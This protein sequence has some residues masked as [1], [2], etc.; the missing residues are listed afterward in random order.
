MRY[1]SNFWSNAAPKEK[2]N[3]L[4]WNLT[5]YWIF[6]TSSIHKEEDHP[7]AAFGLL[8]HSPG[9]PALDN[10]MKRASKYS[11]VWAGLQNG[12]QSNHSMGD[13]SQNKQ[14]EETQDALW[15]TRGNAQ[16][17]ATVKQSLMSTRSMCD[18]PRFWR[19]ELCWSGN[20]N[21]VRI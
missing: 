8:V 3:D 4:G 14:M 18:L 12:P 1:P 6:G 5:K 20:E 7:W 13:R 2:L 16:G 19:R 11:P 9:S 21:E 10:E 15:T 17:M